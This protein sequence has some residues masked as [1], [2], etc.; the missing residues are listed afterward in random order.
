MLG[1]VSFDLGFWGIGMKYCLEAGGKL[2]GQEEEEEE[3][4]T[5]P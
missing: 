4:E 3:G 1:V 5:V 2:A